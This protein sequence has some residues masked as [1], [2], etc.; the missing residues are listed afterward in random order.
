M[1]SAVYLIPGQGR[2]VDMLSRLHQD[3]TCVRVHAGGTFADV[4][5]YQISTVMQTCL[6]LT[7][8]ER[9]SVF[10]QGVGESCQLSLLMLALE[11]SGQQREA[12]IL[13]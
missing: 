4:V 6:V 10:V 3:F 7:W 12:A 8:Q 5:M 11:N 9:D 2:Q 13:S 1:S